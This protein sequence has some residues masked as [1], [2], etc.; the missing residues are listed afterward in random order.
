MENDSH[1]KEWP[2]RRVGQRRRG[3]SSTPSDEEGFIY[4]VFTDTKGSGARILSKNVRKQLQPMNRGQLAN[5]CKH[6]FE[7]E[8][9][10]KESVRAGSKAR[11]LNI[12]GTVRTHDQNSCLRQ[13][14][15]DV[16]QQTQTTGR[17]VFVRGHL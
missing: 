1:Q 11:L 2:P 12:G 7:L 14:T 16:F 9:F 17:G 6:V 13:V 5:T 15:F 4:G 10:G 8:G 3:P